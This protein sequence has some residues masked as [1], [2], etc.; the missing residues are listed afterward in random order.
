VLKELIDFGVRI[1]Y[2]R[3]SDLRT[4]MHAAAGGGH[5]DC[6]RLLVAAKHPLNCIDEDGLTPLLLAAANGCCD[7]RKEWQVR[8]RAACCP[9]PDILHLFAASSLWPKPNATCTS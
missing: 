5:L 3:R 4:P 7:G 6:L 9:P 8:A 1:H 2:A